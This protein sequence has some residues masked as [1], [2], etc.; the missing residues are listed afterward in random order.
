MRFQ[1]RRHGRRLRGLLAFG[2]EGHALGQGLAQF[3]AVEV[4]G[5]ALQGVGSGHG[6][7]LRDAGT[8]RYADK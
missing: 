4:I 7:A 5:G 3:A 1:I 2:G 6:V 8:R